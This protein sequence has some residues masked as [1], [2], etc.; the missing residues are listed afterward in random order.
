MTSDESYKFA[1][2][3][4]SLIKIIGI[5]T[6]TETKT[7]AELEEIRRLFLGKQGIYTLLIKELGK[8]IKEDRECQPQN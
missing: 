3:Q 4:L 1:V 6:I 2:E 8:L 5:N 7:L